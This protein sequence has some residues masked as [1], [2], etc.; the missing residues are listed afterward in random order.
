MIGNG[1]IGI[2]GLTIGSLGGLV[3]GMVVMNFAFCS[4]SL[5]SMGN[6]LSNCCRSLGTIAVSSCSGSRVG[7]NI[8]GI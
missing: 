3:I 6:W 2:G 8:N 7:G 5:S 1:V 4:R